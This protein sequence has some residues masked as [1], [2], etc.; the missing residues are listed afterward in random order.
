MSDQPRSVLITGASSGIGEALAQAYAAPGVFLALSGRNKKRLEKV[1]DACRAAGARVDARVVDV[2]N[3]DATARWIEA[4]DDDTP[5]DLIIANAAISAGT[6]GMDA[7]TQYDAQA[8]EIFSV[9]LAG[10]LNTVHP[11]LP[12][13]RKRRQ[14]QIAFVSSVA[15]YRG[16]PGTAAYCASKAAVKIYGEAWRGW[17]AKDGIRVSVI[18]P[19]FVVSRMTA[20]NKFPMPFIMSAE[21]AAGIIKRGLARNKARIGFP[22]PMHTV[23]WLMGVLPPGWTDGLLS[24][25]RKRG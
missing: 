23:S 12:R 14:G 3:R 22:F 5:L 25:V 9:N 2:A 11:V 8:R 24:R 18:C 20:A 15:A 6:S 19:G 1:A 17:L 7:E 4:V 16:L 10:V 21:K 13:L